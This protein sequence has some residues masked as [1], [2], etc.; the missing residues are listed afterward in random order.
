MNH[1]ALVAL[2]ESIY[3]LE[4]DDQSWMERALT[5]TRALCGPEHTYLGYFYDASDVRAFSAAGSSS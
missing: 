1:E 3:A 4:L 5:A 2:V